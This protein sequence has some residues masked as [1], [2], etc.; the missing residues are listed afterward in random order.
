MNLTSWVGL[1]Q[2][3][4]QGMKVVPPNLSMEVCLEA[5]V[6]LQLLEATTGMGYCRI[7]SQSSPQCHCEDDQYAPMAT[8]SQMMAR[9]QGKGGAAPMG[10]PTPPGATTTGVQERGV[11]QPPP[12]LQPPDFSKWSLPLPEAPATGGLP[13]P[14]GGPPGIGDQTASPW[15]LG[16]KAPA[17]P[18]QAP[19][20]PQGTL[21]VCQPGPF[22][23]A[24]PSQQ[25]APLQSQPAAPHEQLVQP[26]SQPA[27]QCQQAVQPPRRTTGRG[28]L[29]RPTSDGATPATD[30][31]YLD[32]GRQQTRGRG[33]RGRLTS[34]PGWGRGIATN[35]PLT[36]AQRD[37]PFQPS[38]HSCPGPAEMA[39]KYRA[40]GWR[41]D[42]E[43]VLKVYYRHT[44]QTPYREA[45]WVR[46]R[47]CFFDHLTPRKAEA[48]AIKEEAPLDYM[49]YIAEEFE[50]ATGLCLNGLP[51]FTLW[52]K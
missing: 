39:A 32:R 3:V 23:P 6:L 42:L 15:A 17:L 9:M 7:C 4:A 12:G 48:V 52:I 38:C 44:I 43:H 26:S 14:S 37:S 11:L 2:D 22:Q 1:I 41:R 10:G 30:S 46:V 20:T 18:M 21:S 8:W 34:R 16:Q 50:R 31:T 36:A 24:A 51:E 40:S 5:M 27:T 13:M 47:E 33:L 28:L 49:A 19:G 29:A 35:A 45:E 25:A